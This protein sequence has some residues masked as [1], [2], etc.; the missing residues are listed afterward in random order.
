MTLQPHIRRTLIQATLIAACI[1]LSIAAGAQTFVTFTGDVRMPDQ[2]LHPVRMTVSDG[3]E[4]MDVVLGRNGAYSFH[5]PVN[6]RVTLTLES[7]GHITK[8]VS[9]DTHG[10][11]E[12][13]GLFA[14]T[15][16]VAFDL[17]LERQPDEMQLCYTGP[18]GAIAF[19]ENDGTI[20]PII[21]HIER[22]LSV[23]DLHAEATSAR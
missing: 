8:E 9:I 3:H 13:S 6:E 21:L 7:P 1:T 15:V 4:T 20:V 23:T 11:P 12:A 10:V 5:I 16:R 22:D 19:T 2:D 18:V 17:E 14:R